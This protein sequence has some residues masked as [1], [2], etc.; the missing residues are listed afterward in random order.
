MKATFALKKIT[1]ILKCITLDAQTSCLL[2]RQFVD[3][4]SVILDAF[5]KN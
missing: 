4:E 3:T 1:H 2:S 5:L